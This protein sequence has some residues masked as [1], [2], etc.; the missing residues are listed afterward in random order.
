MI[1]LVFASVT[2]LCG[3][4]KNASFPC[5]DIPLCE[6]WPGIRPNS[7]C[8]ADLSTFFGTMTGIPSGLTIS[9]AVFVETIVAKE[10]TMIL[11]SWRGL[12]PV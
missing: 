9:L 11:K 8:R 1:D 5:S 4:T 3:P 7:V 12:M 10:I 6:E 2:A